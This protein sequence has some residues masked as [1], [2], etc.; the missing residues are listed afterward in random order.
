MPSSDCL[1]RSKVLTLAALYTRT[2]R[3]TKLTQT[4]TVLTLMT[5]AFPLFRLRSRT[6]A[7]KQT[8]RHVLLASV[9]ATKQTNRK[10]YNAKMATNDKGAGKR[11]WRD[12]RFSDALGEKGADGDAARQTC[13]ATMC[14]GKK[15][16]S[17]IAAARHAR[18]MT[19]RC[20]RVE[21]RFYRCPIC[22]GWHLTSD[23]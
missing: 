2:T 10:G 3:I 6:R 15:R 17:S 8:R 13:R 20:R 7:K 22:H 14:D 5:W 11:V 12:L 23:M 21:T 4:G 1:G 19:W 9:A 16:Y 18:N